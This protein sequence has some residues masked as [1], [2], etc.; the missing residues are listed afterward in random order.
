M[1]DLTDVAQADG[2]AEVTRGSSLLA[3]LAAASLGFPDACRETVLQVRFEAASGSETWTRRFGSRSFSSRQS[4]GTGRWQHL[5]CERFG[6]LV[7]AMALVVEEDRLRLVL[8][9]WS[10]FGLPLPM[11]LCPR[12]E[13]YETAADGKF[14]FHVEISHP[15]TGLIV[16]Y[17]GWLAKVARCAT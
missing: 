2:I 12:A 13:A 9:G 3:R 16:R 5:L 17:R 11:A 10:L 15:L 6:P 14:R 1:H 4:A 8:R 7:F